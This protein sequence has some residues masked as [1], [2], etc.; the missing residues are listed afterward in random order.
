MKNEPEERGL[1]IINVCE[2]CNVHFGNQ[3]VRLDVLAAC[4]RCRTGRLDIAGLT[5]LASRWQCVV[6][7]VNDIY[8]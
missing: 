6:A 4:R 1:V 2:T 7:M 3:A 5:K 8:C